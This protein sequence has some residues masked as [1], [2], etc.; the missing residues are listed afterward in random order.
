MAERNLVILGGGGF[1]R[2]VAWLVEDLNA[3]GEDWNLVGFWVRDE[4]EVT[5][6][7]LPALRTEDVKRYLPDLWAVA[8]IGDPAVRDRAVSEAQELGCEFATLVHPLVRYHRPSVTFGPGTIVHI[9]TYMS[10]DITI[11][12]HVIINGGCI[13]GHDCVIEDFVTISP[14]CQVMGYTTIRRGAFL[15]VGAMTTEH[16]EIGEGAII[17]AGGVV[18]KDIPAGVTAVGLP[19]KPRA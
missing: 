17:G 13:V 12:S 4:G 7:E 15:G 5:G 6:G 14:G 11:G 3:T 18:V 10:V 9:G 16:R 19:A 1:G 2:E 8:A